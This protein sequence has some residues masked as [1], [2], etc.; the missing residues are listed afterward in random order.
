MDFSLPDNLRSLR[1]S[2]RRLIETELKRHDAAIEKNGQIPPQGLHA[3][4]AFGLHGSDTPK[5]YGGLG[6][7]MLGNCLAIGAPARNEPAS[8]N[9]SSTELATVA[10]SIEATRLRKA[11]LASQPLS[12]PARMAFFILPVVGWPIMAF[13]ALSLATRGYWQ[14]S[15]EAWKWMGFGIAFWIG[16]IIVLVV[17]T[18]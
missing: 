10:G 9:L 15:S 13:I 6:L 2:L 1:R 8:R 18:A 3:I 4:R 11:E 5:R 14:K 7:D 12:W 16:S 17:Y